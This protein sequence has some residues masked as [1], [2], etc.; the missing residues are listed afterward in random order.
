MVYVR[1]LEHHS[2][3]KKCINDKKNRKKNGSRDKKIIR[4]KKIV[5][6]VSWSGHSDYKKNQKKYI[7]GK[8]GKKCIKKLAQEINRVACKL[9]RTPRYKKKIEAHF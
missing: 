4:G 3:E 6:L 8:K 7:I 2:Y 5:V 9:A 1:W